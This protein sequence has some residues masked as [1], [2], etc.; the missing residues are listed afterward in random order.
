MVLA[1]LAAASPDFYR[2][3]AWPMAGLTEAFGPGFDPGLPCSDRALDTRETWITICVPL[4]VWNPQP[5][6]QN[7]QLHF[8]N[9]FYKNCTAQIKT[10][11]QNNKNPYS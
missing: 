9:Q 8:A 1:G 5:I 2:L 7:V 11:P 3:A 6:K 10:P 4:E